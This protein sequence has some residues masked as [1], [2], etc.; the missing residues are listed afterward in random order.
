[1]NL[2]ISKNHLLSPLFKKFIFHYHLG[3]NITTT[4]STTT[5]NK[6]VIYLK[7]KLLLWFTSV[8]LATQ[9]AEIRRISV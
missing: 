2:S 1:M 5:K 4:L 3:K 7:T 9:K 8:I 6:P